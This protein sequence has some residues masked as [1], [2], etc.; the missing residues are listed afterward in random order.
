[1]AGGT[2][3]PPRTPEARSTL[4]RMGTVHAGIDERLRKFIAAQPVYFVA[5]APVDAGGHVNVSPKGHPETFRVIDEHRVAYLDLTGSGAETIAHSRDS[6]RV[7]I[8]F[9]A[10]SGPP[11]IV[12]LHGNCRAILPDEPEFAELAAHFP[13]DPGARAVILVDVT[14]VSDACGYAVPLMS[15]E[16]E[17]ETLRRWTRRK[18]SAGLREYR[19]QK[20]AASIDGLPAVPPAGTAGDAPQT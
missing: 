16:G 20:N 9:C 13:K 6:G 18:G 17:R 14:R 5:S 8:M 1:M 2:A 11:K 19:R 10:F 12:R 7:T 15:Y 3:K 4:A